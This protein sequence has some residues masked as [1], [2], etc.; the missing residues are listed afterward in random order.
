MKV[1][2]LVNFFYKKKGVTR[3]LRRVVNINVGTDK[4]FI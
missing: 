4:I 2:K 3:S 1:L